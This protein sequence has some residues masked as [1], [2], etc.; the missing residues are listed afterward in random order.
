M[1]LDESDNGRVRL[2]EGRGEIRKRRLAD[3]HD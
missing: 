1:S 2:H 3:D